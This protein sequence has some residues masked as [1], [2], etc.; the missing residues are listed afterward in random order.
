[1]KISKNIQKLQ[2]TA[3]KK[4]WKIFNYKMIIKKGLFKKKV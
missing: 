3:R 4:M 2:L 1:M